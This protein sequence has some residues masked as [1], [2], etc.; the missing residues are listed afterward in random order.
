MKKTYRKPEF[1]YENFALLDSIAGCEL[2]SNFNAATGCVAYWDDRSE[3]W[4]FVNASQG[5]DN[6]MTSGD[7]TC[8]GVPVPGQNIYSS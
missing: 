7:N 3:G 1:Y 8:Y 5:C 2:S 6:F 4:I